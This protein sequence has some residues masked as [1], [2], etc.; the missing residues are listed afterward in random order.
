MGHGLLGRAA[1]GL[2]VS[3]FAVLAISS[4]ASASTFT[5]T[6]LAGDHSAGSLGNAMNLANANPADRDTINFAAGVTG[7]IALTNDLPA[8][9]GPTEITGPGSDKLLVDG[10]ATPNVVH[11]NLQTDRDLSLTGLTLQNGFATGNN[12]GGGISSTGANLVLNDVVV[13]QAR[14]YT[15]E[16]GGLS[17]NGGSVTIQN[18]SFIDNFSQAGGGISINGATSVS[19]SNTQITGNIARSY[20]GGNTEAN[21]GG[22][23]QV[24]DSGS[25]TIKDSVIRGNTSFGDGAAFF[26]DDVGEVDISDSQVADNST[27]TN[28]TPPG[29]TAYGTARIVADKTTITDSQFTDNIA[30][31]FSGLQVVGPVT[32]SDSLIANNEASQ[33][34]AGLALG[35]FDGTPS[36]V[37]ATVSNTTITGNRVRAFA[38]GL[39]SSVNKLNLNSTTISGNQILNPFYPT[40]NGAGLVQMRG[41]ATLTSTIVSGN[42]PADISAIGRLP[43]SPQ[44]NLDYGGYVEG[45]YNL[46]GKTT[47]RAFKDLGSNITSTDP[48]LGALAY[49]GAAPT[50]TLRP[51][52]DS[53]VIDQGISSLATDQNGNERTL[54]QWNVPNAPG[55]NGTDIGAVELPSFGP[56]PNK[57]MF[58]KLK[59]NRKKGTATLQVKVPFSGKVQLLGSKTT[60]PSAKSIVGKGTVVLIIKAKGKALKQLK[61]KG[62]TQLKLKVKYSPTGGTAKTLSKSVKLVK[63]KPRRK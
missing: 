30:S 59:P 62:K 22:G 15:G 14:A 43:Q 2:V 7:T 45:S 32:I 40:A 51:A 57:F 37:S 42:I 33:Q 36:T 11:G 13:R 24:N 23:L 3:M 56:P 60:K 55:G 41:T 58:G 19:I 17:V 27:T 5:V 18:S 46:I 12:S 25:V 35:E 16:G 48:Q 54:D 4:A 20:Y 9:T 61:I 47:G 63:K 44:P 38:A 31:V 52:N 6:T 26:I 34:V 29:V 49:D 8:L 1:A 10:E 28:E 53:P 50:Q 21:R 39:S